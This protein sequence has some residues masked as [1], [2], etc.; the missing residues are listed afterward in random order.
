MNNSKKNTNNN[1][2]TPK[3]STSDRK[4]IEF[5][6][7]QNSPNQPKVA[8]KNKISNEKNVTL[9]QTGSASNQPVK[10]SIKDEYEE[11]IAKLKEEQEKEINQI[12]NK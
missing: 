10:K 9:I 5:S 6:P 11:I 12:D 3:K 2:S 7:A 8:K 4:R 1:I